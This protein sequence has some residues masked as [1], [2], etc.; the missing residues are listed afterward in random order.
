MAKKS[1]RV[2]KTAFVG[3]GSISARYFRILADIPR[4]EIVGLTDLDIRAAESR[5][6]ENGLD[7]N[8]VYAN[9][10][11]MLSRAKPDIVFDCTVPAAH[12]QVT[13]KALRAG[14]HVLGEKPM[15]D[16]MSKAR[17]MVAAAKQ[18]RRLY[19]VANQYRYHPF[20]EAFAKLIH[21]K[22]IGRLDM[23]NADYFGAPHFGGFREDIPNPLL[24][25]MA[26]HTFD[27]ARMISGCDPV[28][29]YCHEH[30][31]KGS[32]YRGGN[33]AATAIFEMTNG[34]VFVYRGH[35]C[36]E[37][38]RTSGNSQWRAVGDKGTAVY[39]GESPPVAE[40]VVKK[41]LPG[42]KTQLKELKPKPTMGRPEGH[43]A[44]ILDFIDG[45]RSGRKPQT[46]CNDNIRSLAMVFAA[47]KS[48]KIG[49][50]VEV[51]W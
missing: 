11:S 18:A 16:S 3:C 28:S 9:M 27:A 41:G 4:V 22:R 43:Q 25:E 24:V 1:S 47:I 10:E 14:C 15:S 26:I 17:K 29:V 20:T 6:A 40:I 21:D 13:L 2:L 12:Y 50:K 37:G 23:L 39:D 44:L 8:L 7:R 5:A 31:P 33:A 34:V 19:V 32:W 38:L 48:A 46:H 49:K 35:W 51:N 30:Q 45:V 42:R 36:A